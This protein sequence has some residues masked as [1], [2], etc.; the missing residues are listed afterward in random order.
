VR[1]LG[2]LL[3]LVVT[4]VVS[5]GRGQSVHKNA[6]GMDIASTRLTLG[7]SRSQVIGQIQKA[8]Y[9]VLSEAPDEKDSPVVITT[10]DIRD[11]VQRAMAFVDNDGK[12]SFRDGTLV[13]IE[14]KIA[15]DGIDTGRDLA[16]A[17]YA[18]TRRLEA[19][20]DTK[21]CG[22]QTS[23]DPPSTDLPTMEAKNVIIGCRVGADVYRMMTI[24]WVTNEKF[25]QKFPV[26]VFETLYR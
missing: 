1:R 6:P 10:R 9:A 25:N 24:R 15:K 26:V 13:R 23:V 16:G 8:G 5:V 12:L 17:I 19:E 3:I 2:A 18:V 4:G 11:D 7:S 21:A 20:S 14:M 22:V